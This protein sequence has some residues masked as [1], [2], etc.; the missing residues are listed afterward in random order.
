MGWR[1]VARWEEGWGVDDE[2]S[3]SDELGSIGAELE[4]CTRGTMKQGV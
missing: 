4:S 2:G 3:S 1:E